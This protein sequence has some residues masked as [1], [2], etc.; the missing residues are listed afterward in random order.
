MNRKL[1]SAGMLSVM[2]IA[3]TSNIA[4]N[5]AETKDMKALLANDGD[6]VKVLND[7]YREE[8]NLTDNFQLPYSFDPKTHPEASKPITDIDNTDL[9]KLSGGMQSY[10]DLNHAN[11]D[12]YTLDSATL[13]LQFVDLTDDTAPIGAPVTNTNIKTI[14]YNLKSA[15]PDDVEKLS[16][17]VV[18]AFD[19]INSQGKYT[20]YDLQFDVANAE[21][22]PTNPN[23]QFNYLIIGYGAG[24]GLNIKVSSTGA[25][26]LDTTWSLYESGTDNRATDYKIGMEASGF[27]TR[28]ASGWISSAVDAVVVDSSYTDL[29]YAA[30]RGYDYFLTESD[31]NAKVGAFSDN[32]GIENSILK[33][34]SV[35]QGENLNFWFVHDPE[36]YSLTATDKSTTRF[37]APKSKEE[38]LDFLEVGGVNEN[39]GV[40]LDPADFRVSYL[41]GYS[42]AD[43]RD[44][45]YTFEVTANYGTRNEVNERVTMYVGSDEY[46]LDFTSF[47][48]PITIDGYQDYTLE[49]I[50]Q[51]VNAKVK[52]QVAGESEIT[53]TLDEKY[54]VDDGGYDPNI[55]GTY[56]MKFQAIGHRIGFENSIIVP[57]IVK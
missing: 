37:N 43:P 31:A 34:D 2:M 15:T 46:S 10:V 13:P 36:T 23:G 25:V 48:S 40:L 41:D 56:Y 6:Q 26:K 12:V 32:S 5:A 16:F 57:V 7:N 45:V 35:D 8:G 30:E 17:R 24:T 28:E 51:M 52:E 21:V 39:T 38:L 55:P 42:Y 4:L 44:G 19:G 1:C 18:G 3:A 49:D 20:S 9:V 29:R 11:D 33:Q 50:A 54:I 53:Y 47:N 27:Q 22:D 14:Q